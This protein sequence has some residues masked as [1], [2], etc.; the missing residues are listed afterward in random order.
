MYK[1]SFHL[2]PEINFVAC[3]L[4]IINNMKWK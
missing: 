4:E 1:H 2:N 3:I